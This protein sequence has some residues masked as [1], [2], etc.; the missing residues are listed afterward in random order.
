MQET[1]VPVD[2]LAAG[3]P[4]ARQRYEDLDWYRVELMVV[5]EDGRAWVGPAAFLMCMWATRRYRK[6]SYRFRSPALAPMIESFFHSVS[7]NRSL[8]SGML[9]EHRCVDDTCA[10]RPT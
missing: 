3:S 9:R 10:P 1:L 7:S 8:V 2:F 4:A 5:A 6:L